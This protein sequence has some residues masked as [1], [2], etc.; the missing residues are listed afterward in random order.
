M[1]TSSI[2][3]R[4]RK[5]VL[6]LSSDQPGEVLAAVAAIQRALQTAGADWHDLASAL[7]QAH[8]WRQQSDDDAGDW[9]RL[10][11]YCR[12]HS[13]ALSCREQD[14]MDTLARWRGRPTDKQRA[15]LQA[16]YGRLRRTDP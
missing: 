9:R 7:T 3:P 16:I 2:A 13:D 15:W 10:H 1:N 14:F 12:H 11:K 5:L 4:L 6:L 8:G